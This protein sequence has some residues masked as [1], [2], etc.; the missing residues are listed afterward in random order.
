MFMGTTF[1]T[2][3]VFIFHSN[4]AIVVLYLLMLGMPQEG[5]RIELVSRRKI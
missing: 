4:S 2:F 1:N 3:Y 5:D